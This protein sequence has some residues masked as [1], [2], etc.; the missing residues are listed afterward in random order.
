MTQHL[1][2]SF[3]EERVKQM[4][5]NI[6]T[7]HPIGQGFFHSGEV[8][9][10]DEVLTYVY[11]CGSENNSAL[12]AAI[13]DYVASDDITSLDILFV[14][15]LDSDHVS[16]LDSLLVS[17]PTEN[18]VL[19]YLSNLER[20]MLVAQAA[21]DNQLTGTFLAFARD[22]VEWFTL[23]GIKRVIFIEGDGD[24]ENGPLNLPDNPIVPFDDDLD[25]DV[26]S[27]FN[28]KDNQRFSSK[29]DL[30]PRLRIDIEHLIKFAT[31]RIPSRQV[32]KGLD[33][34]V[35][36]INHRT[37]L[38]LLWDADTIDWVFIPFVHPDHDREDRFRKAVR[39][40]FSSELENGISESSFESSKLIGILQDKQKRDR[41]ADC[42]GLIR[43]NRN[44]TSMSV[45]S[46]PTQ[47]YS[48]SELSRRSG[49]MRSHH[50]HEE[51]FSSQIGWLAT[52]DAGL[53]TKSRRTAFLRHYDQVIGYVS[54]FGLPH[55]GSKYNF[56]KELNLRHPIVCFASAGHRN[57]YG[58]PHEEVIQA[59]DA[60]VWVIT[61][62]P[63]TILR[64]EVW[65]DNY[66]S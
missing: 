13:S 7:Q 58:H 27:D 22:P 23:R 47:E 6:R 18:V 57:K 48:S 5:K 25:A 66:C 59:L 19:P 32:A 44:L 40:E 61:E 3:S 14:S 4:L 11:D 42:Y 34:E 12:R 21:A 41:L 15:H 46:G 2:Y 63:M 51:G 55:H 1:L 9:V 33:S 29:E 38:Q 50:F 10:K 62:R 24:D 39:M 35:I 52:G 43:R 17:V 65:I 56:H 64:E 45:Y 60:H 30:P 53:K 54:T 36:H 37:P 20:L 8:R 49:R 31:H 16:G 28:V 26:D